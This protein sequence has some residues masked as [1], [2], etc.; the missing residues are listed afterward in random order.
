M[1]DALF[2]N[3]VYALVA[4]VGIVRWTTSC[5][6]SSHIVTFAIA[7]KIMINQLRYYLT[8][9]FDRLLVCFLAGFANI[10]VT[11][12]AVGTKQMTGTV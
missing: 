2:V 7:L 9:Y 3:R 11:G 6:I 4:T 8:Y 10:N 12:T 1:H 5:T